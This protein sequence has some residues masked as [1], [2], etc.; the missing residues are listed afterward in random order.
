MMPEQNSTEKPSI[1]NVRIMHENFADANEAVI[2]QFVDDAWLEVQDLFRPK[3]REIACR[4]LAAH[5]LL[6]SADTYRV[7][8]EKVDEMEK[9]Y[10]ASSRSGFDTTPFGQ[11]YKQLLD[12]FGKGSKRIGLVV[13]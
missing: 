11:K 4:Y 3:Y 12:Q 7:K 6:L 1:Q 5:L 13:V 9:S 2:A 8:S 10:F